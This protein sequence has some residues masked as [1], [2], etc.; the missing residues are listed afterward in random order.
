MYS[1]QR[2]AVINM[3][4]K[5]LEKEMWQH[6][7]VI[8]DLLEKEMW[9]VNDMINYCLEEYSIKNLS[10]TDKA[11]FR[12][13]I[14]R[15]MQNNPKPVSYWEQYVQTKGNQTVHLFPRI[16]AKRICDDNLFDYFKEFSSDDS[17]KNAPP[18]NDVIEMEK[19]AEEFRREM[20]EMHENEKYIEDN[21]VIYVSAEEFEKKYFAI[22]IEALFHKFFEPID[23]K[24][25][26]RDMEKTKLCSNL[27]EYDRAYIIC[28]SRLENPSSYCKEKKTEKEENK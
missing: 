6:N 7:D 2:K 17:I 18:I 16:I 26:R 9:Q 13:R 14:V 10:D 24:L 25:L 15:E 5:L 21:N 20:R 8:K 1:K 22:M 19:K 27:D 4:Y 11:N 3:M 28:R 12:K 23:K